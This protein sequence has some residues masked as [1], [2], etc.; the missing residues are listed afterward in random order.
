MSLF[1]SSVKHILS[2]FTYELGLCVNKGKCYS[3]T[4]L[5]VTHSSLLKK[6]MICEHCGLDNS[7]AIIDDL[8]QGIECNISCSNSSPCNLCMELANVENAIARLKMKRCE[9][10]RSINRRHSPFIRIIPPEIIATI[11]G[12][13]DTNFFVTTRL[14]PVPNPILLSSVCSDWR[15]AVVGTPHLWSSIKIDL[16]SIY[17]TAMLGLLAFIDEWLA[18][19]GRL[20]LYISL[21]YGHKTSLDVLTLELYRPI[22][23]ILNLYSSRWK[24]LNTS[25]PPT[26]L[27]LLQPDSLPL[28]EQLHITSK[29]RGDSD[30]VIAFP[31]TPCLNMVEIHP[32]L[33]SRF[34]PISDLGIQ[35]HTVTHLYVELITTRSCFSLLS[36]IPRLVRC[37][38]H[39]V[40]GEFEYPTSE[41]PILSLSMIYLSLQFHNS[42]PFQ[43]LN[44]VKLPSLE[45]LFLFN[46]SS[47]DP[48]MAFLER[49]ACSLHT[50]SL[51]N[52]N[53]K[54]VNKLTHLL[55]FLSPSL[56]NLAISRSPSLIRVTK[57]FLSI[58]SQ[59]YTSQSEGKDFLPHLE[60]F[61]YRE[62]SSLTSESLMLSNLPSRN[63]HPK[64]ANTSISL[65][66]VYIN[67]ASI[68]DKL[69]PNDIYFILDHLENDGILTYT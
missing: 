50:L 26:L 8:V 41:S 44:N 11:S 17:S 57:G 48:L 61:E 46:V 59:T 67:T 36:R 29:S 42:D 58:L 33:N 4:L 9:L 43:I 37:T 47:I 39:K 3:F 32:L 13:A 19:S 2:T 55:K 38:F 7:D 54:K 22:F 28:L 53:M 49:S 60:I 45:A 20:P 66:S 31:P 69:I 24:S 21:R 64:P 15:R 35:W 14:S 65:R 63:Y 1:T 62:D 52:W 16:P 25:I 5:T 12:F 51:P 27:S 18:R 68:V 23:K 40:F 56:K 30:L 10:K 6:P 34:S